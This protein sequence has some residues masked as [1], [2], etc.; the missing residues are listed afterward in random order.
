MQ[1]LCSLIVED[2]KVASTVIN[3][4]KKLKGRQVNMIP[5]NY[6]R[7]SVMEK[8]NYPSQEDAFQLISSDAIKVKFDE[9]SMD[10]PD[11]F[12]DDIKKLVNNTF[13]RHVMT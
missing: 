2:D 11:T 1:K 4:N 8:K 5:L 12:G 13:C 6:V 9:E 3:L 7:N 10:Y